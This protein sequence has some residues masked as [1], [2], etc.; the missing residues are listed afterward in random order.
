MENIDGEMHV[1]APLLSD[2]WE[3]CLSP[4]K[5]VDTVTLPPLTGP[6]FDKLILFG[7][8][9]QLSSCILHLCVSMG[10]SVRSSGQERVI[11]NLKAN[12]V[13][14]KNMLRGDSVCGESGE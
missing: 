10:N 1:A 14:G 6:L 2:V 11:D 8:Y 7:K 12:A 5:T 13:V 3:T 4:L 9:S